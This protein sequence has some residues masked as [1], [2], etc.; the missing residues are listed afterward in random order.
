MYLFGKINVTAVIPEELSRL[1]D[2][3]Y[4]LWWSWN[5]DAIDLY[6]EIDLALWE[7]VE[8]NPVRFLKEVS[9]KKLEAKV[10]DPDYM[11]RYNKVV[12]KFDSYMQETDTWFS[13]NYPDKKD[14][15]IA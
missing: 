12:Q 15:M 3:A 5:S 1:K 8:K 4:N 11:E 2:I 6:R 13:R 10:N 14:H 7:K 9:Q